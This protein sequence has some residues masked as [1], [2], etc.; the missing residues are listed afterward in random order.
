MSG[1][2]RPPSAYAD[3]RKVFSSCVPSANTALTCAHHRHAHRGLP[4]SQDLAALGA[5][6]SC[7]TRA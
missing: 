1:V 4:V 3:V 7:V 5:A 6:G 2:P